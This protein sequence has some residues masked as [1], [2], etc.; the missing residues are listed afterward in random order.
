VIRLPTGLPAADEG[1][2]RVPEE[3]YFE[4]FPVGEMYR[5][6]GRT[7]TDAD[8]RLFL[9]ATGADH[10]NHTDA[11]YCKRHPIFERPVALGVQVLSVV[12]GFI[13]EAI[14]RRSAPALNYGHDR[15]RYLKPV[16]PG[17]TIHAEITI[18]A[19]EAKNN[20]WGLLTVEALA[21]NQ[22]GKLV[23]VNVNKLL[24]QRRNDPR[25]GSTRMARP[26][27]QEGE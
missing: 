11:E 5:S 4:D 26:D 23:L 22:M 14:T 3:L 17:D 9:G 8:I 7:I 19:R 1:V 21:K 18:L 16:Y 15:I 20:E 25:D 10:P 2:A 27:N 13:A 6:R 24:I 12:D